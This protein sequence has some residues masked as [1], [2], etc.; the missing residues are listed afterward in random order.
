MSGGIDG[1]ERFYL[2][3]PQTE[4]FMVTGGEVDVFHACFEGK[5]RNAVCIKMM[6]GKGIGEPGVVGDR[7]FVL[8]HAPFVLME[9][10]IE[11]IVDEKTALSVG[12]PI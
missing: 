9:E 11:T 7:D 12:E 1:V 10:G 4:R 5:V 8:K 2:G 3:V 6:G